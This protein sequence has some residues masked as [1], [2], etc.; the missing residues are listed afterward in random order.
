MNNIIIYQEIE[1]ENL[2]LSSIHQNTKILKYNDNTTNDDL[3]NLIDENTQYI[4]FV[5]HYQGYNKIPFF[6]NIL[7]PDDESYDE[8]LALL[9]NK[10]FTYQFNNLIDTIYN[11]NNNI[12]LDLITCN[13]NDEDFINQLNELPLT[14]RYSTNDK[15]NLHDW[16]QESH[17]IDIKDLYFN[18]N[19][20]NWNHTLQLKV[21][22]MDIEDSLGQIFE[23][24]DNVYLLKR[25]IVWDTTNLNI[26][27]NT[28]FI[29]LKNN[30]II[31]GDY[32]TITVSAF[33]H[34]GFFTTNITGTNQM[35]ERPIIRKLNAIY[36]ANDPLDYEGGLIRQNQD[37]FIVRNCKT[38]GNKLK[39][40]GGICGRLCSNFI[41]ENCYS[42]GVCKNWGSGGIIGADSSGTC[43]VRNCHHS[44]LLVHQA[45]G[46]AGNSSPLANS[47]LYIDNCYS[48]GDINATNG[49]GISG[50][51]NGAFSNSRL[52][53]TNCYSTGIIKHNDGSGGIV[54]LNSGLR[55]G[56]CVIKNCYSTGDITGQNSGGICGRG[57]NTGCTI[58]NCY[59]LGTVTPSNSGGICGSSTFNPT[60]RNCVYNG[61]RLLGGG[62][63]TNIN[64][65]RNLNLIK[66]T[67]PITWDTEYWGI[68]NDI[69]NYPILK[70]FQ[71]IP[72]QL[73]EYEKF[74]YEPT[75]NNEYALL[76]Y[77][78]INYNYI[79]K[80]STIKYDLIVNNNYEKINLKLDTLPVRYPPGALT[81]STTTIY[82]QDYGNGTYEVTGNIQESIHPDYR[83]FSRSTDEM[84]YW[85]PENINGTYILHNEYEIST[86]TNAN[87]TTFAGYQGYTLKIKLPEEIYL[88]YYIVRPRMNRSRP[89]ITPPSRW[90][91]LG[92]NDDTNWTVV[93]L[94]N[95]TQKYEGYDDDL[96]TT[97]DSTIG[98]EKEITSLISYK[99]YTFVFTHLI[100][101]YTTTVAAIK[102]GQ[103]ELYGTTN[104]ISYKKT[105]LKNESIEISDVDYGIYRTEIYLLDENDITIQNISTITN[106]RVNGDEIYETMGDRIHMFKSIGN[107]K[108][109]TP[110][111]VFGKV[112]IVGGGGG[113]GGGRGGGGGGAGGL[114]YLD[115]N[116]I[117]GSSN[118]DIIV[119]EGGKGGKFNEN[120]INGRDSF[121]NNLRAL[122]GGGGGQT[123]VGGN[124]GG[125]GGGVRHNTN[126]E[127]GKSLQKNFFGFGN[128]GGTNSKTTLV[129]SGGGGASESGTPGGTSGS[130]GLG[131]DG[132]VY[133][134]SGRDVYYAGGGGGGANNDPNVSTTPPRGGLGGG[135][136]GG[137][138][139]N[140]GNNGEKNSGGGGGAG[141]SEGASGGSEI[142]GNGGSGIV[143][144]RYKIK[145][146]DS[147]VA[148]Q[149]IRVENRTGNPQ[150]LQLREVEVYDMNGINRALSGV[151][152]QSTDLDVAREASTAINGDKTTL[153]QYNISHTLSTANEW[154]EL[155]L[156]QEYNISKIKVFNRV[157]CCFDRLNEYKLLLLNSQRDIIKSMDFANSLLEYELLVKETDHGEIV[158]INGENNHTVYNWKKPNWA[159]HADV[160]VVAGGGG[161]THFSGGGGAG[162]VIFNQNVKLQ[163]EYTLIVGKGGEA[164]NN[165]TLP[166]KNG[167]YSSGFGLNC[168]GGGGGTGTNAET[169][170]NEGGSGGGLGPR[171]GTGGSGVDGQ[172]NDGGGGYALSNL[173]QNTYSGGSGGGGGAGSAGT[174]GGFRTG[175]NGGNGIDVSDIFGTTYGENG[176]FGGGGAG[177]GDAREGTSTRGTPGLGG[178]GIAAS[179]ANQDSSNTDGRAHSG[180]GAGAG[181]PNYGA[182]RNG[183]SGI[184]LVKLYNDDK[185]KTLT[186][187]FHHGI[188]TTFYNDTNVDN[189]LIQGRIFSN[190]PNSGKNFSPWDNTSYLRLSYELNLF[191]INIKNIEVKMSNIASLYSGIIEPDN[192]V[193][194]SSFNIPF[195]LSQIKTTIYTHPTSL[196]GTASTSNTDHSFYSNEFKFTQNIRK[197][198]TKIIAV[199]IFDPLNP[200]VYADGFLT[201]GLYKGTTAIFN[202]TINNSNTEIR[203]IVYEGTINENS[204]INNIDTYRWKIVLNNQS[205]T[206]SAWNF[207]TYFRLFSN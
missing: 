122:G 153:T 108:L 154:W 179:G 183:G 195:N 18:Q 89:T 198:F 159:S 12:I 5:F 29:E 161:S 9:E 160:L 201:F 166:G 40:G 66:N 92:S 202:K 137:Y 151:A 188:F 67:I 27:N 95:T 200:D 22:I 19:I 30:E 93:D 25:D 172:G 14:I 101:S 135:G 103:I 176:W 121:F 199:G 16:I 193:K 119:G 189:A 186:V 82:G 196:D 184:I 86:L 64:T 190:S 168:M 65:F 61:V 81:D 98:G 115:R 141:G 6:N 96:P 110:Y 90:V 125:S 130:V 175:G 94:Q 31:D 191:K 42:E 45:G 174:T 11:Y 194:F 128:D 100:A 155:D 149:Y 77:N 181:G 48:S 62:S 148:G 170:G 17:N 24:N 4:G 54:G 173:S 143:I 26:S 36:T 132:K 171:G 129:G 111:D 72:W 118:I 150:P 99:Y 145:T 182:G 76:N 32:H 144:V 192:S 34:M 68:G 203:F 3:I 60:I 50:Y 83:A 126:F 206:V 73:D 69:N 123:S 204:V 104:K 2:F 140:N 134:I 46:I 71:K 116:R 120:G 114:I 109:F 88:K 169:V 147:N 35:D 41:V 138:G 51:G 107:H 187:A 44:G 185:T 136:D 37:Y 113:G 79:N 87:T 49:G 112:L 163:D 97:S 197:K 78:I 177:F 152:T 117:N 59:T 180:G 74:N 139:G 75:L 157:D 127:I 205:G 15:G 10:H 33:R 178:G 156:G 39:R 106:A 146:D 7:T 167:Y 142:G 207:R 57:A 84:S 63:S 52:Y 55:G 70:E 165:E 131:G 53:I 158:S 8:N 102:V 91:L 58:E 162:G 47:T 105:L 124:D 85:T 23:K 1:D 13:V 20:N 56:T 133:N 164:S 43:Y 21:N 28:N 80:K 38:Y